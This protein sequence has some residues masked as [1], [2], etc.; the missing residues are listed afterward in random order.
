MMTLSSK[1]QHTRIKMMEVATNS[2]CK[3][4][5]T[6]LKKKGP[7]VLIEDEHGS[8]NKEIMEQDNPRDAQ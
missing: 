2:M 7:G 8:L 3:I 5:K 6:I 4:K 1:M